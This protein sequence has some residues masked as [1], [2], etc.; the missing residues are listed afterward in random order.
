MFALNNMKARKIRTTDRKTGQPTIRWAFERYNPVTKKHEKVRKQDIPPHIWNSKDE[1]VV[2]AY[3][4][5]KAAEEDAIC[6]RAKKKLEWQ[7]KYFD[8][9]K[10]VDEFEEFHKTVAPKNWENDMRYLRSYALDFFLNEFN[11]N[12]V[13]DWPSL[14]DKFKIWLKT[15][16]P[17]K[18]RIDRLSL[19]TQNKII[20]ML[21]QFIRYNSRKSGQNIQTMPLYPK[22]MLPQ[23]T[24]EMLVREHEIPQIYQALKEIREESASLFLVLVRSGLRINEAVGMSI[25]D[26]RQGKLKGEHG[27]K[28]HRRLEKSDLGNYLGYFYLMSQ[29]ALDV[30][31]TLVPWTDPDGKSWKADS[32]P[33]TSLKMRK[34]IDPRFARFVPIWDKQAWNTVV[35]LYNGQLE[36]FQ[37]QKYGEDE[38]DY[39]L[40]DGLTS[41][42]F[43]LDLKLA[44]ERTKLLHRSPHKLRHTH[45][46]WLYGAISEDPFIAEK[47]G[48]H[49]DRTAL[50]VY[51]HIRQ[52][53]GDEQERQERALDKLSPVD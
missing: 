9:D 45:L 12:N 16:K 31:R 48:G 49:R 19:N 37:A 20:N 52:Q 24:A 22:E 46:T 44:Q 11:S 8:F 3:A 30:V 51:S 42:K 1:E 13:H 2:Y 53:L 26:I 32:V 10:L 14:F 36:L 41:S 43:Y 40:F 27:D 21:N 25:K 18:K 4:S 5:S 7:T 28:L 47:I 35:T 50:E 33:R 17:L 15:T 29:P 6:A 39:L 23:V 34:R 38:A